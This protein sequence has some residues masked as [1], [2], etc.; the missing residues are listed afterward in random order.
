M[1]MKKAAA[2][3]NPGIEPRL[4]PLDDA[5]VAVVCSTEYVMEL[6]DRIASLRTRCPLTPADWRAAREP[7]PDDGE[8][9]GEWVELLRE[10]I[11]VY[12]EWIQRIGRARELVASREVVAVMDAGAV[13]PMDRWSAKAINRIRSLIGPLDPVIVG[14]EDARGFVRDGKL[15]DNYRARLVSVAKCIDDLRA[16]VPADSALE[17]PAPNTAGIAG[18]TGNSEH[19]RPTYP[20]MGDLASVVGISDDTFRRVR[21]AA[22]IVVELRGAAARNRRYPPAEVDLLI[23]AASA[24]TFLERAAMVDKWKK[25]G[26]K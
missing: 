21:K 10:W 13:N 25:W 19:A 20:T 8:Y 7:E 18:G 2:P 23:R 3:A 22:G 4:R 11:A 17:G 24:G 6:A 16:V 1:M 15:P 5:L 9:P 12:P 26:S 14:P